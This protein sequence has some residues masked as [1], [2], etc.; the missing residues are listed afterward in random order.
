MLILDPLIECMYKMSSVLQGTNQFMTCYIPIFAGIL[1]MGGHPTAGMG[2]QMLLFSVVQGVSAVVSSVLLPMLFFYLA[3]CLVSAV[4]DG[5]GLGETA[6][7]LKK[8]VSWILGIL[9]TVVVGFLTVQSLVAGNADNVTTKAAKFMISSAVPVVGGALSE[10]LSTVKG[11][12][13]L[14]RSS[15]G[16]FGIF[17]VVATFLPLLLEL[18]LWSLLTKLGSLCAQLFSFKQL[19]GLLDGMGAAVGMMMAMLCSYGLLLVLSTTILLLLGGN[20]G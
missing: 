10:A 18:V 1:A 12:V 11:C 17:I 2:Y 8:A 6:A 4:G 13:S 7:F 16:Y 14:L 15:V 9:V 19:S 20:G 3:I 5:M